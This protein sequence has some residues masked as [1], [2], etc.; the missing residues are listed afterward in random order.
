[1]EHKMSIV[2]SNALRQID[3]GRLSLSL[4]VVQNRPE[5]WY[6]VSFNIQADILCTVLEAAASPEE[7]T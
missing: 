5:N 7:L 4:D 1:M 3:V 2:V 6:S